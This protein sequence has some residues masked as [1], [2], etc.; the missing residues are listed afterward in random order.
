[1]M[2]EPHSL[3]FCLE[4]FV[5]IFSFMHLDLC[6]SL[7][8]CL[9]CNQIMSLCKSHCTDWLIK[10]LM[11]FIQALPIFTTVSLFAR[12]PPA[13]MV[14]KKEEKK[15]Y[16]VMPYFLCLCLDHKNTRLYFFFF[17]KVEV[18]LLEW[19]FWLLLPTHLEL[20]FDR[21]EG[22]RDRRRWNGL[23]RGWGWVC[24]FF[25][26]LLR[27]E[28]RNR[29][30]LVGLTAEHAHTLSSIWFLSNEHQTPL[31]KSLTHGGKRCVCKSPQALSSAAKQQNA[32]ASCRAT[33]NW[34]HLPFHNLPPLFIFSP[35]RFFSPVSPQKTSGEGPGRSNRGETVFSF[36]SPPFFPRTAS[37][38]HFCHHT[39]RS[40]W[41]RSS[42]HGDVQIR[43]LWSSSLKLSLSHNTHHT[44][45]CSGVISPGRN[46]NSKRTLVLIEKTAASQ[47]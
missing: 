7:I 8:L 40:E 47:P 18:F 19:G 46:S 25:R 29:V 1:M 41:K 22:S 5:P 4:S 26:L 45:T 36:L 28:G 34:N 14:T 37:S 6:I 38:R 12:L 21:S 9:T 39:E 43:P 3:S 42:D 44:E 32:A 24:G 27:E 30:V 11:I 23:K 2:L 10:Y 15:T 35:S 17:F 33:G 31:V 16:N 20:G 13:Q